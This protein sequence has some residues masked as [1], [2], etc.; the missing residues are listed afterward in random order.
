[1]EYDQ[2]QYSALDSMLSL[3]DIGLIDVYPFVHLEGSPLQKEKWQ[4]RLL[5]AG[6]LLEVLG[7]VR[8]ISGRMTDDEAQLQKTEMFIRSVVTRN[9]RFLVDKEAVDA[10]NKD[11]GRE[12]NPASH[13][14]LARI[15]VKNLEQF[16]LNVWDLEYAKLLQKQEN[17]IMGYV[18]CKHCGQKLPRTEKDIPRIEN[19]D[20][21]A[22]C[23]FCPDRD[24]FVK[25]LALKIQAASEKNAKRF[26]ETLGQDIDLDSN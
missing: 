13:L 1:M 5:N 20:S 21:V 12:D 11:N 7:I 22:H 15:G 9:G 19:F 2:K 3:G 24:E 8:G 26:S 14:E 23:P 10:Y 25:E 6:E 16:I 4:M 17:Y 18:V